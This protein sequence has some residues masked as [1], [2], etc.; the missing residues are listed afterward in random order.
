MLWFQLVF[1]VR[2]GLYAMELTY[3]GSGGKEDYPDLRQVIGEVLKRHSS[4]VLV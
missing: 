3:G 1:R 4:W 2:C